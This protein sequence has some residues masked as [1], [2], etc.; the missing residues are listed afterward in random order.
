LCFF[1]FFR[2]AFGCE[3]FFGVQFCR[4]RKYQDLLLV[5]AVV[6]Q[7][8]Q[9]AARFLV[10]KRRRRRRRRRLVLKPDLCI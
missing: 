8:Q 4:E 2:F 7:Q 9:Q 6:K 10:T 3:F 1:F 5:D